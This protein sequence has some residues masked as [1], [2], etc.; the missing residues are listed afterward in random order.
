[1]ATEISNAAIQQIN[2][3]YNPVE[4]RLLLKI[5]FSDDAELAVWLTRRLVKIMWQLL[6][7]DEIVGSQGTPS[8]GG[9]S[10]ARPRQTGWFEEAGLHFR[11]QAARYH[12]S[13]C[14]PAG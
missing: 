1:M 14:D 5:G 6:Q 3:S 8:E 4:D 9:A 12:Q 2:I 10:G 11:I 7:T 13:A